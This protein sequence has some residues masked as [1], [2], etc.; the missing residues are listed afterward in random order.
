MKR[1]TKRQQYKTKK[2]RQQWW[3]NSTWAERDDY[4]RSK[5]RE[6]MKKRRNRPLK[7]AKFNPEYPWMTEGVN[8]GN[9]EQ[10]QKMI[11]KKNPWL[12]VA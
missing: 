12:K 9:R 2:Q 8:E 10:W 7:S 5:Q 4:I 3:A 1:K 11:A 6:R